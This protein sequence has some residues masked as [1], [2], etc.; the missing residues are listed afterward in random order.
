MLENALS[1]TMKN[2][3]TYIKYSLQTTI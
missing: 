2:F 3:C 1:Y